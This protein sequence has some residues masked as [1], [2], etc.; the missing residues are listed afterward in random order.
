MKFNKLAQA[1][2]LASAQI[3]T[4]DT[5]LHPTLVLESLGPHVVIIHLQR[6]KRYVSNHGHLW[7]V[8]RPLQRLLDELYRHLV[9]H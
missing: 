1:D 9:G 4:L 8:L 7:S 3:R 6:C 2:V 5:L